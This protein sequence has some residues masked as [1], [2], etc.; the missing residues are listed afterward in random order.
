MSFSLSRQFSGLCEPRFRFLD[1]PPELRN[2]IYELILPVECVIGP[3]RKSKTFPL[4]CRSRQLEGECL[5]IL[6]GRSTFHVDLRISGNYAN[7][8]EWIYGPDEQM[9]S[10]VMHLEI[11]STIKV[12]CSAGCTKD[13]FAIFGIHA[14]PQATTYALHLQF[15]QF[16]CVEDGCTRMHLGL[17]P[18]KA[19]T[20]GCGLAVPEVRPGNLRARHVVGWVCAIFHY[21]A[22]SNSSDQRRRDRLLHGWSDAKS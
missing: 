6:L 12:P 4:M 9:I 10:R 21:T 18:P 22:E 2:M 5:S 1:L 7:F 17:D 19:M 14:K 8:L 20:V 16:S 15:P 3:A 13:Q 11:T